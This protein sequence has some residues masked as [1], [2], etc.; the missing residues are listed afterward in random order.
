MNPTHATGHPS[1]SDTTPGN[2]PSGSE[3]DP[4]TGPEKRIFG[5]RRQY[6]LQ[7]LWACATRPRRMRGRRVNDRRYPLLDQFDR[8]MLSL[9]IA[10]MALSVLDAVFTLTL[11]ARGGTE[12]NPFMNFLLQHSVWAFTGFKMLLT[13]VPAIVLVAVGNLTLFGLIRARSLLAA[14]VG[15]YLG[16][17]VYHVCLLTLSA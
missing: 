5:G 1:E 4:W 11:L 12:L 10:L 17:M 13:G 8:T 9:A 2:C 7:T 16:L 15:L 6:T 14:L 3:S